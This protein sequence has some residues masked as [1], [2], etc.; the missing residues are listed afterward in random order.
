MKQ[1]K[2]SKSTK[3]LVIGSSLLGGAIVV[4]LI[5]VA[6]LLENKVAANVASII[7]SILS[8]VLSIVAIIYTF[9]SNIQT[10]AKLKEIL[11][12]GK[13]MQAIETEIKEVRDSGVAEQ[14]PEL[15]EKLKQYEKDLELVDQFFE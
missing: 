11:E 3:W 14:A 15:Q 2:S 4:A 6:A 12:M 1:N 8:A 13:K 7:A 9:H 5:L 10:D